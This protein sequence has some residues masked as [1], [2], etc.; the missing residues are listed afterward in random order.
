MRKFLASLNAFTF[1]GVQVLLIALFPFLAE[2]LGL[3]L[4]VV[5]GSF[6]LGSALFMVGSPFWSQQSD[7]T[8]RAP[9]LAVGA[10]GLLISLFILWGLLR[11][12]PGA[13]F[14]LPLLV[15]SRVVYGLL[16]SAI[17]PVAQSLQA[18]ASGSTNP[19]G[20]MHLHSWSL[21]L[22]RAVS[23]VVFIALGADPE[24][25]FAAYLFWVGAVLALNI[26]AACSWEKVRSFAAAPFK[27]GELKSIFAVAFLFA[28]F[29]ETLNSS[30]GGFLKGRFDLQGIEASSLTARL[31]LA[32][33][34]G[35]V[36]TQTITRALRVI[37]FSPDWLMAIGT[38]ALV[39]GGLFLTAA[40]V[41]SDLNV[42]VALLA[43]GIGLLPP[44]YL[45]QISGPAYGKR[46][47]LIG[48]AHTAGYALGMG[49][50]AL[51]FQLNVIPLEAL[52]ALIALAMLGFFYSRR[53][54]LRE[55]A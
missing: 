19:A 31:L 20:A 45:A 7:A 53:F 35:V 25:L 17:A 47:G 12:Y 16:A 13:G 50:A 4:P 14:A 51:R 52:L 49:L 23:L 6:G 29:V 55:A 3:S 44:V 28:C 21:N 43:I 1:S 42:A 34:L 15:L 26:W 2:K 30:L 32:C 46:A 8:G 18:D 11:F 5:I 39:L 22:G 24:S 10:L 36:L 40:E 33:A 38:A 9:V 48:F 27:F 54:A 41:P 37:R